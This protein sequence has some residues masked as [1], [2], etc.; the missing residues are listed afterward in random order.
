[1]ILSQP[2]NSGQ[3]GPMGQQMMAGDGNMMIG[4]A[5]RPDGPPQ[6]SGQFN[7]EDDDE[8]DDEDDDDD[9]DDD[10]DEDDDH[11]AVEG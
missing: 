4:D 10:D 7:S 9:D 2:G 8:S 6:Q 11:V 5:K 3:L 1:M